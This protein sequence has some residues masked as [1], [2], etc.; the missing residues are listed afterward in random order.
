MKKIIIS[1]LLLLT[2]ISTGLLITNLH[3]YYETNKKI[4]ELKKNEESLK[5]EREELEN[6]IEKT[7]L[8]YEEIKES[9]KE[10]VEV[11][12]EWKQ[13]KEKI[14]NYLK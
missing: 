6:N 7:K 12:E 13:K 2:F 8:E 14:E 9:K 3:N 10:E 4:E 5:K 11:Y 1:V